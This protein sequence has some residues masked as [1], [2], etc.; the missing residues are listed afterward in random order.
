V[1]APTWRRY[2]RFWRSDIGA[3]LDDE[4]RFHLDAEVEHLVARGWSAEAARDE[5]LRGFG[6]VDAFR[7]ECRA[8]DERRMGRA[9]RKENFTVLAQDL[10][11]ALR[12]LRRQPAFTAIVV[13]T[14]ALGIG[15]NT[16]I[17]SIVNGVLL[18]PL[19]YR[20]PS[21]LV[22]VWETKPGRDRPLVSYPN[23]LDWRQ[24]QRRVEDIAAYNPFAFFIMTGQGDADYVDG[25]LVTGNYFPLVGIQP[26]LGR[27]I[28]PADDSPGAARTVMLRYGFFQS[29][30]GGD[31]SVIGRTLLLDNVA[32]TIVGVLR[33]DARVSY[34]AGDKEP[35]VVVPLGL[36]VN[37]PMYNRDSPV[38]FGVGRLKAGV[39]VE[40]ARSDLQRVSAELR[41]E[42]PGDDA[43]L[44]AMAVPMMDMVVRFIKPALQILIV[45]VAFVLLIVCANVASLVLSRSAARRREFAVRTALGAARSRIVRQVL[46]ESVVLAL[47]G[48][49]LGI[50]VAVIGV[51]LLVVI[52]PRS[53]P[54]LEQITVDRTVLLYAFAVSVLTGV[55]F[56]LAPALQSGSMQLTS[57]LKEG[58][59]GTSGA[60]KQRTRTIL[61][62]AEVA[63]ALLLLTS[64]G[65]LVRSFA[66]LAAVDPGF[67]T[68]HVVGGNLSLPAARYPNAEQ[69]RIALDELLTRVRAIPGVESA[70]FGS[71]TPIQPHEQSEVSF[72]SR[73]D[74]EARKPAMLNMTVVEP[75][76]FETLGIPFVGG[77]P[78][79]TSDAAGQPQ[80]VVIS[81]LAARKFFPNANPI[82]ERL[83][84]GGASDTSGWRTIV[85]IVKDTRTDGLREEPRGTL[86]LPRAQQ[87]MRGG[88]LMVRSTLPTEQIARLLRS[89]VGEI[90][91]DVPLDRVR[92][93][94]S[95]VG[96]ELEGTRF[97]MLLLTLFAG[98][99]LALASVGIYGVISYNVAQRTNEIGVRVALGARRG[100][101]VRLVVG[102]AVAMTAVGVGIGVLL[103][104]WGGKSLSAML[105]GVGPR[106]P[107]AL[108]GASIF[109]LAVALLAA[110]APALRASRIDP[111]IAMR[112]D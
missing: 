95:V 31:P 94:D 101:I 18:K 54:R 53:L 96:Q 56:G 48:G 55:L 22:M 87:E 30:F 111:T 14:L 107:L 97:A 85:G 81:E 35:D 12:S 23:Y 27:L 61:T 67:R 79:A 33:P 50:G 71:N 47:A 37:E 103:A 110:L 26:A 86:Y 62:I 57:A 49:V 24:R 108:G 17:F 13:I 91:R 89:T 74:A 104:L 109:L 6:D 38:L 15:A 42:Y 58:G 11:Y 92:T 76:Y 45:A 8:A 20:E 51:K 78:L 44:G 65:L 64:A 100:D 16:A 60:S 112:A 19:P 39:T 84:L 46:T 106:D 25:S 52:D 43:G 36:F 3:D 41:A 98:V 66:K 7:R 69:T 80:V 10:R 29:R 68:A 72:Q 59:R 40:Q 32:Y 63:F 2:L 75:S 28:G 83:K 34:R 1:P 99:A 77:R 82:G 105:Y 88:W 4:F 90:D 93:M 102:Q 73:P 5:A 70:T 21:R 9:Q